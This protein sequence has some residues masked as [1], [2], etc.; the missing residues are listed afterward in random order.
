MST[1]LNKLEALQNQKLLEN[2]IKM[3]P[4]TLRT[5]TSCLDGKEEVLVRRELVVDG[6]VFIGLEYD[7]S[8]SVIGYILPN[9]IACD[10]NNNILGKLDKNDEVI[11]Q[12]GLVIAYAK[13]Y[14]SLVYDA[15]DNIVGY[16]DEQNHVFDKTGKLTPFTVKDEN[17]IN[18]SAKTVGTIGDKYRLAYNKE[19]NVGRVYTT[20]KNGKQIT[21][22]LEENNKQQKMAEDIL[23]KRLD[24]IS[25]NINKS[26][27]K[28][29]T[30][31]E[32][33]PQTKQP[34]QTEQEYAKSKVKRTQV[35]PEM[36]ELVKNRG[37]RVD[38]GK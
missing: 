30:T 9:N 29:D 12:D 27:A 8:G 35:S 3:I 14:G 32:K 1:R 25:K 19:G 38:S 7:N 22:N 6:C 15:K 21:L 26:K 18:S 34:T 4:T 5:I 31:A 17:I 24:D 11:N 10:F 16:V 2:K 20:D 37:R 23:A 36:T 33:Q 28:E 13:S